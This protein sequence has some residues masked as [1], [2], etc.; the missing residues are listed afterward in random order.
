MCWENLIFARHT[1]NNRLFIHIYYWI[2][3]TIMSMNVLKELSPVPKPTELGGHI[4]SAMQKTVFSRLLSH[5]IRTRNLN[6]ISRDS[7]AHEHFIISFDNRQNK[8]L[9]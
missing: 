9:V 1:E 4:V 8:S 7:S 5:Y 3:G 6:F 2:Q